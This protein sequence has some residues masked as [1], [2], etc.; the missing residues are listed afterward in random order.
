ME[1]KTELLVSRT[2]GFAAGALLVL[3]IWWTALIGDR[4]LASGLVMALCTGLFAA[5]VL[6]A[7]SDAIML[8]RYYKANPHE[9]RPWNRKPS[10]LQ[11]DNRTDAEKPEQQ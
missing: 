5:F 3:A 7:Y 2:A 10:L 1:T 8:I 9:L 4:V 6:C 11:R